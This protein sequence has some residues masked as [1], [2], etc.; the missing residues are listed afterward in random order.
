MLAFRDER[1]DNGQLFAVGMTI[2]EL[3]HHVVGIEA[4]RLCIA[5]DERTPEDSTG[6]TRDVVALEVAQQG[7]TD[8][9]VDRD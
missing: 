6:P 3:L 4:D 8:F 9:G 1:S 5:P 2:Q 7:D